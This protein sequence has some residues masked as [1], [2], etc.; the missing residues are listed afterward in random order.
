[1][2]AS[3]VTLSQLGTP[4]AQMR[5]QEVVERDFN[6]AHHSVADDIASTVFCKTAL[7]T[8]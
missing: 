6:R 3:L 7:H 2:L 8:D 5:L 1:M 4:K